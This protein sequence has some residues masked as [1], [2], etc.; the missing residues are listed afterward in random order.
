MYCFSRF[1][2]D[3]ES[4][5]ISVI[6]DD[7]LIFRDIL[8][9][10]RTEYRALNA[11]TRAVQILQNNDKPYLCTAISLPP[12]KYCTVTVKNTAVSI[13]LD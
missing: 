7:S 3:T 11:G 12:Y 5:T 2:N 13:T 9:N 8:K 10:H 6:I 1:V 4:P